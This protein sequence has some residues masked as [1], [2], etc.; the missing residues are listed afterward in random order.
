MN[1]YKHEDSCSTQKRPKGD[2]NCEVALCLLDEIKLSLL[3]E[4]GKTF[5]DPALAKQIDGCMAATPLGMNGET[6]RIKIGKYELCEFRLPPDDTFY[7]E[8][9]G[10]EGAQMPKAEFESVVS[11]FFKEHF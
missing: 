8:L 5:S 3:N 1:E 11:K 4:D 9:I 2:C 10:G 6:P 7:I